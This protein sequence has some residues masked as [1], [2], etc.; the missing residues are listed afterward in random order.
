MKHDEE[1]LHLLGGYLDGE[2]DDAQRARVEQAL[3]QDASLRGELE[4]MRRLG[5]LLEGGRGEQRGDAELAAF[6][7]GVYN[8]LERRVGWILLLCGL[9]ALSVGGLVLFITQPSL[10]WWV[11]GPALAAG[12]GALILL[13][14]V[15]RERQRTVPHDRYAREVHR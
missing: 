6:W 15:W 7:G 1:L 14:S 11:K 8:R 4:A 10:G 3:G 13:G 5:A 12:A 2:L 9:G